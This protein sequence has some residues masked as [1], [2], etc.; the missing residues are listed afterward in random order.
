MRV[1]VFLLLLLVAGCAHTPSAP[2]RLASEQVLEIATAVAQ[3]AGNHL[4]E[5]QAPRATF[6]S[7]ERKW[8]VYWDRKP[9]GNPGG[10]IWIS[11]DDKTGDARLIP[12]A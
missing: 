3:K 6:D 10:Y 11:V 5:Y 8:S 7:H 9:P 1:F 2:P 12:S 4:E